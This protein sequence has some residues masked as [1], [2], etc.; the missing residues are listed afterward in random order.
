MWYKS[1]VLILSITL[2]GCSAFMHGYTSRQAKD[3]YLIVDK[4]SKNFGYKRVQYMVSFHRG[5]LKSFI[6]EKGLPNYIYEF[7]EANR[8]GVS[9]LYTESDA[10][11]VFKEQSWEPSS[12]KMIGIRKLNDFEKIRFDA[13][14]PRTQDI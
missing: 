6:E 5:E 11:Y 12:I 14:R 1:L 3:H 13:N 9:L 2:G 10:V 7:S 4:V 8:A